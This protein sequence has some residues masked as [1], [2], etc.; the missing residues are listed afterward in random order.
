MLY[1]ISVLISLSVLLYAVSTD[2]TSTPQNKKDFGIMCAMVSVIPYANIALT[3]II[4]YL[5]YIDKR[6]NK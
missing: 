1:L 3:S 4:L 6:D 2:T 5:N